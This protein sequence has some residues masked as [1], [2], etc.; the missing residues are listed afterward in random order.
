ML[1]LILFAFLFFAD[2]PQNGKMSLY[3]DGE[4]VRDGI[5]TVHV[6]PHS[7]DDL[8]WQKTVDD[9]FYGLN[10]GNTTGNVSKIISEV[11]KSLNDNPER[12]FSQVE[13]K[14]FKMWWDEQTEETKNL[15]KSLVANGQLELINGGW[16]MNDEACPNYEDIIDNMMIGH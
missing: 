3:Y 12:K 13:M 1:L 2:E 7:H 16:S 6:I 5:L 11:I 9:Y 8:G 4:G 15:T 14:F 10:N